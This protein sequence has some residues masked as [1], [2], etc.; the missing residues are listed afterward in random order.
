[1]CLT[2]QNGKYKLQKKILWTGHDAV[3]GD[4]D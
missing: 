1:M 2:L 4:P 3:I